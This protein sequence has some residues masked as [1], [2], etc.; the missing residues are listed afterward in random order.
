MAVL[1]GRQMVLVKR[2]HLAAAV[3]PPSLSASPPP[4]K[5]AD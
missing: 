3:G 2:I 4:D 5:F 1:Y